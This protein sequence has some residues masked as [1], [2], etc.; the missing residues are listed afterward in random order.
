MTDPLWPAL[1]APVR[2]H[3]IFPAPPTTGCVVTAQA[4]I[5]AGSGAPQLATAKFVNA[6]VLSEITIVL[7]AVLELFV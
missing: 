4:V 3:W 6:G 1:S 5:A 2:V 7:T